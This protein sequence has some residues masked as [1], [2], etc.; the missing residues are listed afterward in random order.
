M[1]PDVVVPG[2]GAASRNTLQDMQLTKSPFGV[3]ARS[4]GES[5]GGTDEL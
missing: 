4:N 5:G 2:H 3:P 1:K